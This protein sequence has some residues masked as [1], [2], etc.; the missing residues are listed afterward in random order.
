VLSILK[1]NAGNSVDDVIKEL[2]PWFERPARR[3]EPAKATEPD[4]APEPDEALEKMWAL[5]EGS[6]PKPASGTEKIG[7]NEPCPCGSGKKYKKC[8]G[9]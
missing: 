9:P 5:H 8:C 7:R 3:A 4:K 2:R 6:K 1:K